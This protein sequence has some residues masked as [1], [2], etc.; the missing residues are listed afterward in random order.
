M[1]VF[2]KIGGPQ[3]GWFIVENPIKMD[4]LGVPLFSETYMLVFRGVFF[5]ENTSIHLF[6][7]N[8]V[9][10]HM[11]LAFLED[12][13]TLAIVV[14]QVP[15]GFKQKKPWKSVSLT[16]LDEI[17]AFFWDDDEWFY[18]K[19]GET[20]WGKNADT[21]EFQHGRFDNQA[22]EQE[23]PFGHHQQQNTTSLG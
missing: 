7:G 2:P 9:L 12:H 6:F 16:P 11:T 1:W 18:L 5:S 17:V 23:M 15:W 14:Q 4:D 8:F 10:Q 3:N 13:L 20:P 21:L 22:L 19:H